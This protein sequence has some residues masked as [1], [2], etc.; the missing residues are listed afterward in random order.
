M[1]I[2]K[3][4]LKEL[5]FASKNSRVAELK[6]QYQLLPITIINRFNRM[7]GVRAVATKHLKDMFI[8]L[9]TLKRTTKKYD[10]LIYFLMDENFSKYFNI[11]LFFVY[12][13]LLFMTDSHFSENKPMENEDYALGEEICLKY[14]SED[15]TFINKLSDIQKYLIENSDSNFGSYF[16]GVITVYRRF[17]EERLGS[18]D[19]FYRMLAW[20]SPLNFK[21]ITKF[22]SVFQNGPA[23]HCEI[24]NKVTAFV[25]E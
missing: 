17:H 11:D 10:I 14:L 2:I 19:I 21:K 4:L 15:S 20:D 13:V 3:D 18:M 25:V 9:N 5:Q 23:W 8:A 24:I 22:L 12:M 7:F 6:A 16:K 1:F